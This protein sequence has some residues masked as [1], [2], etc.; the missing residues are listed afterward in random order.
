MSIQDVL[1]GLLHGSWVEPQATTR[2]SAE[3]S[4]RRARYLV[5]GLLA[6]ITAAA[7]SATFL[8][9]GRMHTA[10]LDAQITTATG[11]ARALE[12]QITQS[13]RVI[14][15]TFDLVAHTGGSS[16]APVGLIAAPENIPQLRSISIIGAD[17]RIVRSSN[18]AN[19][20]VAVSTV[21]FFPTGSEAQ[22]QFRV[23]TP[24][25]GRDLGMQ[26]NPSARALSG[27][28]HL[29][30]SRDVRLP[31]GHSVRLVAAL[32][33]DFFASLFEAQIGRSTGTVY[34]LRYDGTLLASTP[35]AH[36][37]AGLAGPVLLQRS[38]REVG[39]IRT[40]ANGESA[41]LAWRSSRAYP[42]IVLVDM[43]LQAEAAAWRWQALAVASLVILV[44][45]LAWAGALVYLQ[46]LRD[47]LHHRD[48][49]SDW[50]RLAQGPFDEWSGEVQLVDEVGSH[51]ARWLTLKAV[52]DDQG[53]TLRHEA[54]FRR[55]MARRNAR[56]G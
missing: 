54:H 22:A 8:V 16:D 38:T 52:K 55:L 43:N 7:S 26:A 21:Q 45:L 11:A 36:P 20:G 44:I 48:I 34:L 39:L 30:V 35:D 53:R 2:F 25:S 40:S 56:S 13:L 50:L 18:A 10:M 12:G 23:G 3:R 42:L 19:I 31:A 14:D 6:L 37:K 47:S 28:T 32:N 15:A 5:L 17:G 49:E 4:E 1:L 9:I 24:A 41:V 46:R 51:P 33:P 29:P 27:T